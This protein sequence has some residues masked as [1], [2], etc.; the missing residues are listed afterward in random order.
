[1][2]ATTPL[3]AAQR[4]LART[5][6]PAETI[7]AR[8][9]AR[10]R[11][12]VATV[13][14]LSALL[15]AADSWRRYATFRTAGFD[16]GIFDQA[17]RH[18]ASFEAPVSS[19][20]GF[21]LLGDHFSPI[22]ATIAPLFWIWPDVRMLGFVAAALIA[23]SVFP[24]YAFTE[25]RFGHRVGL[26][27]AGAYVFWWPIQALVEFDF[28]EIAFAVPLVAFLIDALD[29]RRRLRTVALCVALLLVREDMG[30][31]VAMVAIILALRGE[32]RL[33]GALAAGGIGAFVLAT[34]IVIPE[35]APGGAWSYWMYPSLGP[36]AQHAVLHV[37]RHPL[38]TLELFVSAPLKRVTLA[39]LLLP[40]M[41][42]AVASPY[43]LLAV[44]ILAERLLGSRELLWGVQFHY[45]S[46]LAP[47][48]VMATVDVLARAPARR[49]RRSLRTAALA[50]FAAT[51]LVG[52]ALAGP[53]FPLHDLFTPS[54]WRAT[55]HS[56]AQAAAIARLPAHV[57]VAA[58]D[59]LIPHLIGRDTVTVATGEPGRASWIVIDTD[60]DSTGGG[61]SLEPRS[62]LAAVERLGF[63]E[64]WSQGPLHVLHRAAPASAACARTD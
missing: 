22:L 28:H 43:S 13:A 58:D 53:L 7:A 61:L 20:K 29:Q 27:T 6:R 25:R 60:A 21:S 47:I 15:Y 64:T 5:G 3:P 50:F 59:H 48:V 55:A 44:P 4:A 57:C 51:V 38:A 23:V 11:L 33:A 62:V 49:P 63:R 52:T 2:S 39:C 40:P 8:V 9:R 45:N 32:R 24:V 30:F 18:Y 37:A 16:A 31:V 12:S 17:I 19:L 10:P 46:I 42:L 26:L 56:R 41:L 54:G 36:D 14:T 34:H 35:F 1:M